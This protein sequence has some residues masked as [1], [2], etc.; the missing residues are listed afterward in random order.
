MKASWETVNAGLDQLFFTPFLRDETAYHRAQAIEEL[1]KANGWTWD[2][3]LEMIGSD[4]ETNSN[5]N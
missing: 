2:Q 3:V 4:V 5:H 1:L